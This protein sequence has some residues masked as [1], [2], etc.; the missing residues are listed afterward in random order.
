[1]CFFCITIYHLTDNLDGAGQDSRSADSG[2][3]TTADVSAIFVG[4]RRS[5][6]ANPAVTEVAYDLEM[7]S[8][9]STSKPG[10]PVSGDA[11]VYMLRP[12]SWFA[13]RD[14]GGNLSRELCVC[15]T[16]DSLTHCDNGLAS[17]LEQ[18]RRFSLHVPPPLPSPI[19]ADEPAIL[20]QRHPV[21]V[22]EGPCTRITRESG[23]NL[24]RN[25]LLK[26]D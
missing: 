18:S 20:L 19:G 8:S 9:P 11:A 15:F 3:A 25:P 23:A 1:M 10:S 21:A 5:C 14:A 2:R 7:T 24:A 17:A 22:H 6:F 13:S 26:E 4:G 16:H 12:A